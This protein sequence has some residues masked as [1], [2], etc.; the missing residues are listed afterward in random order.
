MQGHFI[1]IP[2][3]DQSLQNLQLHESRVRPEGATLLQAELGRTDGKIS[4]TYPE[5][6]LSTT[7]PIG[8][9][10]LIRAMARA[11]RGLQHDSSNRVAGLVLAHYV[12]NSASKS[13]SAQGLEEFLRRIV[14]A[15][16][17]MTFVIPALQGITGRFQIG[18][19]HFE[20]MDLRRLKDLC[21][22]VGCDYARRYSVRLEG[23]QSIRSASIPCRVLRKEELLAAETPLRYRVYDEYMG[24]I[25]DGIRGAVIRAFTEQTAL[26]GIIHEWM[27]PLERVIRHAPLTSIALFRETAHHNSRGW[28]VPV[29]PCFQLVA[30]TDFWTE[31]EAMAHSWNKSP[32][33]ALDVHDDLPAWLLGPSRLTVSAMAHHGGT[34]WDLAGLL[35]TTALELILCEASSDLQRSVSRL[36]ECICRHA[37]APAVYI[38]GDRIKRLYDA[39]SKFVHQ[40][41]SIGEAESRDLVL[42]ARV[43][44]HAAV[45][46]AA[47]SGQSRSLDRS[48]WLLKLDAVRGSDVAELPVST[49][50][51]RAVGLID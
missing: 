14:D 38:S 5:L 18:S 39:R 47:V 10:A 1:Q 30:S 20:R 50:V 36:G 23:T 29:E 31:G 42:L 48:S 49:E 37:G 16:V 41:Q 27:F 8:I 40:G 32:I 33:G 46:A 28:V 12:A 4:T 13:R 51:L 34:E 35:A 11:L 6:W 3:V 25:A 21:E 43:T 19:F 2:N 7:G 45:R 22:R 24:A 15:N 26:L 17:E 9:E 44:V